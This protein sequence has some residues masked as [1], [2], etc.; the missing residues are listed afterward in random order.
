MTQERISVVVPAYNVADWLPRCLDSL[1]AQT[2]EALE[3]IVVNDGSTD[4]TAAVAD[5]YAAKDGVSFIKKTA[6]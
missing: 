6:A 4:G 5:C 1:R 3:I 2:H